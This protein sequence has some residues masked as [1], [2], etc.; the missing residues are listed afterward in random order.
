MKQVEP[1]HHP[2]CRE[3]NARACVGLHIRQPSTNTPQAP[4]I[5]THEDES[6]HRHDHP[7]QLLNE[8]LRS[9]TKIQEML[10]KEHIDGG[11]RKRQLDGISEQVPGKRRITEQ[12]LVAC[13]T[14]KIERLSLN[15]NLDKDI[16]IVERQ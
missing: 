16:A 5:K 15:A 2:P 13:C 6:P 10:R 4:R 8:I 9:L 11:I 14:L 3:S 1:I 12:E 7:T